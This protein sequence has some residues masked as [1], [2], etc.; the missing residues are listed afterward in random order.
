MKRLKTQGMPY[1]FLTSL[2]STSLMKKD[3]VCALRLPMKQLIISSAF[4]MFLLSVSSFLMRNTQAAST[5]AKGVNGVMQAASPYATPPLNPDKAIVP[6][7]IEI[8]ALGIQTSVEPVGLDAYGKMDVPSTDETVAWYMGGYKLGETG[9][10]VIAGHYDT[11]T[12]APAVF[13]HLSS[14]HEGDIVRVTGANGEVRTFTVTKIAVYENDNFPVIEVFGPAEDRG[15]NLITCEGKY[16]Q[17][18]HNYSHRT[19]VYTKEI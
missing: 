5:M 15:L 2:F 12:G 16:N 4:L 7:E 9:Q 1:L 8:P 3:I 6:T 17:E 18:V 19:V 11:Q 14:L 13:Y 10:A